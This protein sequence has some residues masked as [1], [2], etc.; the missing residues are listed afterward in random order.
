ME[1]LLYDF[2]PAPHTIF[3]GINK[4][5]PGHMAVFDADGFRVE[6]Y[7]DLPGPERSMDYGEAKRQLEDLLQDSVTRRLISDVPLGS[8][9]SGGI[10]S[11]LVT[12]LMAR[13]SSCKVK[14]FSIS[15][16]GTTHDESKWSSLAADSI[17]TDH[18]GHP[19]HYD[20]GD[21]FSRVVRHFGEPFGDSSAIPTWYLSE[22]TRRHVTVALSGDGGD[23]LFAG[24]ERYL[25]R[26][27][28]TIYD[29]I[30]SGI[31]SR[32]IEPIVEHLP[33]TTDYYGTSFTKKL[34]LFITAARRIRDNPSAVIPRTFSLE[35]VRLLTDLEY[36][37][38]VDPVIEIARQWAG[39]DPVSRMTF[40]DIQTYMSEDILTKVDR[41]SM[42]HA[43]EVRSP[44]LDYRLVELAC[45]MPVGFKLGMRTTKRI[46][47]DVARPYVP[48][49]ILRRSKYGF[50]VPLGL[51]F[52][53]DLKKWAEDRLLSREP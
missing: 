53:T 7:W 30:P 46:L 8:F 44:L 24:Y 9:L 37:P 50:Q 13:N 3:K 52:K 5:L 35:D 21:V 23:E 6:K 43:L 19:V 36:Q 15:F 2:I 25:A 33:A 34:K 4:L 42:A 31:R 48:Q 11:T 16:P 45:R 49:S 1:F 20:I 51:W 40:T 14:T 18:N 12:A 32:I 27:F 10:D 22:H 28:Q 29:L 41:M 17:G 38:D 39:L 26:R 47:R